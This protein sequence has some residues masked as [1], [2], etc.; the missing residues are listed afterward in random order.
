MSCVRQECLD[1]SLYL[2]GCMAAEK[3]TIRLAHDSQP[4]FLY[5]E[6]EENIVK[7]LNEKT[8]CLCHELQRISSISPSESLARYLGQ[9]R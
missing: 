3:E 4:G 2:P 8:I 1:R 5:G 9:L 7:Y 6:L